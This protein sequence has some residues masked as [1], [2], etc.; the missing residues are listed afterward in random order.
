M[1]SIHWHHGGKQSPLGRRA[2]SICEKGK[3]P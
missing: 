2:I 3:K 1:E